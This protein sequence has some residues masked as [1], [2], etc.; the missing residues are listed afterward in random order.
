[1]SMTNG[2]MRLEAK[3]KS[4]GVPIEAGSALYGFGSGQDNSD[5]VV[6]FRLDSFQRGSAHSISLRLTYVHN[7]R[8]LDTWTKYSSISVSSGRFI[9][10]MGPCKGR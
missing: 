4:F 1:M 6:L 5:S 2:T 7:V 10:V 3:A 8:G 9:D